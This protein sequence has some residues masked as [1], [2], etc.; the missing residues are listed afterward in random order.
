MSRM[1]GRGASTTIVTTCSVEITT[2]HLKRD[3]V[4]EIFKGAN[5]RLYLLKETNLD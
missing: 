2:I 4:P 1:G 5:I 3:D